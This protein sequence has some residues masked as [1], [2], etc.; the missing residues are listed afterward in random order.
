[1]ENREGGRGSGKMLYPPLPSLSLRAVLCMHVRKLPVEMRA[2]ASF[3]SRFD[4]ILSHFCH[5]LYGCHKKVLIY[6]RISTRHS[7]IKSNFL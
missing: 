7:W 2:R 3:V 4:A 5:A 1:V 6:S